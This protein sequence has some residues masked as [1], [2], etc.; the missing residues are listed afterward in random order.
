MN[1][2]IQDNLL[3]KL[4]ENQFLCTIFTTN[5]V[6]IKC[7]VISYDSFTVLVDVKGKQQLINKSGI[8]TII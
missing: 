5:G 2:Q 4:K 3:K 8:S 7:K 1:I 6:P